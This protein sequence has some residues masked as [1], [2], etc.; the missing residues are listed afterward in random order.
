MLELGATANAFVR[1]KIQG[2]QR[3]ALG[4]QMAAG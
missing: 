3:S 4:F 2:F 1:T